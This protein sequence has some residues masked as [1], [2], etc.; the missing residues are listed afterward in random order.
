MVVFTYVASK[1]E[2][3]ATLKS[4]IMEVRGDGGGDGNA[5]CRRRMT[6]VISTSS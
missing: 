6:I 5:S 3:V 4:K 2:F 1:E